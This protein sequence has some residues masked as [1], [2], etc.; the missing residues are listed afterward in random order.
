[1]HQSKPL[2]LASILEKQNQNFLILKAMSFH[3]THL[4]QHFLQHIHR[5][6]IPHIRK[7]N[8]KSDLHYEVLLNGV[9]VSPKNY[10][11]E[12]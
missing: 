5:S 9:P 3:L 7:L 6:H 4:L 2:Y 12:E 11:L 10:I 8:K 1:M